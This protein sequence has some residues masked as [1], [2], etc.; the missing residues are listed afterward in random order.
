MPVVAE[1]LEFQVIFKLWTAVEKKI[2][3]RFA[4]NPGS[5]NPKFIIYLI[6]LFINW[7]VI[8]LFFY[9]F[10]IE[11]NFWSQWKCARMYQ[12]L[13]LLLLW[14]FL[15]KST[16]PALLINALTYKTVMLVVLIKYS[17]KIVQVNKL[18]LQVIFKTFQR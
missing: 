13:R 11:Q 6:Y 9:F 15:K 17:T 5:L 3:K 14:Q 4:C 18:C 10:I 1:F 2:R 7:F 8:V 12:S 16:T